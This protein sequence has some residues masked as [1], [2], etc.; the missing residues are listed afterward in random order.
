MGD[1]LGLQLLKQ[2]LGGR[3]QSCGT[4]PKLWHLQVDSVRTEVNRKTPTWCPEQR[5][6]AW[7]ETSPTLE[8]VPDTDS[9][10]GST[11]VLSTK[12][13]KMLSQSLLRSS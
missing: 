10:V 12:S 9:E 8:L 7:G 6:V 11:H 1:S 13:Q 2:R 4:E 3:Q 5:L